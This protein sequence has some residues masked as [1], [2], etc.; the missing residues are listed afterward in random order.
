[1]KA[2][3]FMMGLFLFNISVAI[4]NI[5]GIWNIGYGAQSIE[6]LIGMFTL[7]IVI[8]VI[9]ALSTAAA[10]SKLSP[11]AQN[12]A[13]YASFS[14]I[15]LGLWTYTAL[16]LSSISEGVGGLIMVSVFTAIV[17]SSLVVGLYQMVTGGWQSYE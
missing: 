2:Y 5:L 13:V 12:T 14:G 6:G 8:G 15:Y 3:H 4:F 17:M 7:V 11:Y 1:M 16:L 9:G 10:V